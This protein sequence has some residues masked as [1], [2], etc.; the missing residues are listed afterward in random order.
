M[1]GVRQATLVREEIKIYQTSIAHVL[2]VS[3]TTRTG[4]FTCSCAVVLRFPGLHVA[5]TPIM[6]VLLVALS[7]LGVPD[8]W[9]QLASLMDQPQLG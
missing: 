2:L 4:S 6:D 5:F 3:G 1:T 7:P 9:S 8:L